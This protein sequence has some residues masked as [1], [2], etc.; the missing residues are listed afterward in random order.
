M[1]TIHST[2]CNL[3]KNL[4]QWEKKCLALTNGLG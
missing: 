2:L 4:I 3:R 1:F